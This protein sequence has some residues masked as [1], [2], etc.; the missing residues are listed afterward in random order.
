MNPIGDHMPEGPRS[1]EPET[2]DSAISKPKRRYRTVATTDFNQ[3]A[4]GARS[5][6]RLIRKKG[7]ASLIDQTRDQN[8]QGSD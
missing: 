2:D 1:E 4:S 8:S 3:G 7:G 5:S 6:E